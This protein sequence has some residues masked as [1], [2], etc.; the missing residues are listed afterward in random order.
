MQPKVSV[1]IPVYKAEKFI[2]KCVRS[3]FEQTLD[4]IEYIFVNDCTPDKSIEKI[5]LTLKDY[6]QRSNQVVFIDFKA[7]KGVREAR[8]IGNKT[9]SGE[10]IIHCDSDDWVDLNMYELMYQKAKEED[11]DIVCCGIC[12]NYK[13]SFINS[14]FNVEEE[15]KENLNFGIAPL[16]G[17]LCNKLISTKMYRQNGVVFFDGID[18]GEDLGV[19]LQSRFYSK[20]TLI[21]NM[22]MYHYNQMNDASIY[23]TFSSSKSDQIILCA[24]ELENF[25]KVNNCYDYFFQ[26][27]NY[28][29]FQSKYEY[30]NNPKIRDLKKWKSIYPETHSNIFKYAGVPFNLKVV[31]WLTANGMDAVALML[32]KIKERFFSRR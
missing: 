15:T 30:I 16:Y 3:L 27:I 2:E 9:A 32:L 26:Q 7:N 25:F 5:K 11:A 12:V 17:S 22:P 1:I 18:M 20:K 10:F 21:I 23:T 14:L 13:D 19:A 31:S 8:K 29:K 24:K 4:S 28:L 6:P